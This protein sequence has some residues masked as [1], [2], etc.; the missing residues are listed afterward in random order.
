[1]NISSLLVQKVQNLLINLINKELHRQ[2]RYNPINLPED[3]HTLFL[4]KLIIRTALETT[5]LLESLDM[6]NNL[7]KVY[8]KNLEDLKTISINYGVTTIHPREELRSLILRN[9]REIEEKHKKVFLKREIEDIK[10]QQEKNSNAQYFQNEINNL[11]EQIKQLNK[12]KFFKNKSKLY[13]QINVLKKEIE[14][15]E[16]L[17]NQE[18]IK[19]ANNLNISLRALVEKNEIEKKNSINEQKQEIANLQVLLNQYL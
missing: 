16:D 2:H 7:R 4:K 15:F 12:W 1:M 9:E 17:N 11:L 8:Y 5:F 14:H 19:C 13:N 3:P 6:E 18:K 10:V